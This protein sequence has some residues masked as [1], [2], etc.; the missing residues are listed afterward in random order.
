[1]G[2]A[3]AGSRGRLRLVLPS[4]T[5]LQTRDWV[6]LVSL[7]GLCEKGG[8]MH[9]KQ[10]CQTLQGR[11][12]RGSKENAGFRALVGSQP[13]LSKE[14]WNS[15][16]LSQVTQK[17]GRDRLKLEPSPCSWGPFRR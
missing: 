16:S 4:Y 5:S 11:P 1:M 9:L 15:D 10:V 2:G 8:K 6:H 17:L 13:F 3:Q 14:K 7:T 12:Y